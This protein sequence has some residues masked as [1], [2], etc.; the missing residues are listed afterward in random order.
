MQEETANIQSIRQLARFVT[1]LSS[2]KYCAKG[3]VNVQPTA[4]LIGKSTVC[5]EED[6]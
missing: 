6:K 5:R 1:V 2:I 3:Q 4:Q